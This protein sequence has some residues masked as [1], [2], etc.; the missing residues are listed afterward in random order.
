MGCCNQ[1]LFRTSSSEN[2]NKIVGDFY[3]LFNEMWRRLY[4]YKNHFN[5]VHS[6]Q[7]Q[8]FPKMIIK[9]QYDLEGEFGWNS[10]Q[11]HRGIEILDSRNLV[12]WT[13]LDEWICF[14]GNLSK[15]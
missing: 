10:N 13:T 12:K 6:Q 1:I 11:F 4:D 15:Y 9:S 7:V 2:K 14:M 8:I 3:L 5:Y